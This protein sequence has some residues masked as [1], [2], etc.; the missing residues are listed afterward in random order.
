[1]IRFQGSR[2]AG[3]L[4][5]QVDVLRAVYAKRERCL[6]PNANAAFASPKW[7]K[8]I[9]SVDGEVD[10]KFW[11]IGVLFELK[12]RLRAGDV[13]V[14]GAKKYDDLD[15]SL[16]SVPVIVKDVRL[17]VP[18]TADDWI[19]DRTSKLTGLLQ[20]VGEAANRGLLT[21]ASIGKDGLHL[22][23]L[24]RDVPEDAADIVMALYRRM[25]VIRITDLLRNVESAT[26]FADA[27]T[28]L[29]TGAPPRDK[30]ALLTVL[31]ADGLNMGLK[32]MTRACP[33]FS[34]WALSRVATWHV[35]QE[36]YDRALAMLIEAQSALPMARFWG[37]GQTSSSDGQFFP[38]GGQGEAFNL[39]NA[40]YGSEPEAKLYTHVSDQYAPFHVKKI[41][42]TAFE[43]PYILDGLMSTA[44]GQRIR[45]H[46]TDTGGFTDHIFAVAALLGFIFGPRIR[47]L[48]DKRLYVIEQSDVPSMMHPLIGGKI[49][50]SVIQD[51]WPDILRM[52]ASIVAGH[53]TP[54]HLLR[55]LSAYPMRNTLA[56]ALRE[57]GRIERSIFI[58]TWL[59]DQALQRRQ[60]I[61]LNKGEAHHALESALC[62]H[63]RG[64]IRDRTSDRQAV[65]AAGLNFLA[66][67]VI[68]HNTAALGQVATELRDEGSQRPTQTC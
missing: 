61:G 52:T 51:C 4:L 42:A 41:A 36:T 54:S 56:I 9:V 37:E 10:P 43:A 33:G 68:Y 6:A 59:M 2:S 31:L 58:L 12:D 29:R 38:S 17:T 11:E 44:A 30:L 67:A 3:K 47:G 46:I 34:F 39:I 13:W 16:L 25:P 50:T 15:T 53:I 55:R 19:E 60:Q 66:A 18:T 26:G 21:N 57:V 49:R 23:K 64:E 32:P 1:M 48:A 62:L 28:E 22:K 27:F 45:K 65:R 14:S 63:R 24:D 40:K 35:R 7:Q 20:K 8:R 5:A